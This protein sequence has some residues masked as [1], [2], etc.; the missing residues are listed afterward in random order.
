MVQAMRGELSQNQ[1]NE[2]SIYRSHIDD[3]NKALD[4]ASRTHQDLMKPAFDDIDMV[5]FE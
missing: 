4:W 1:M 5:T 3:A 2:L